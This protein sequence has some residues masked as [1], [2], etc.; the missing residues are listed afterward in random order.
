MNCYFYGMVTAIHETS[1]AL[2]ILP[3]LLTDLKVDIIL[4]I[5]Q[6]G[7]GAS[8][9]LTECMIAR[10]SIWLQIMHTFFLKG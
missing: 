1:F 7:D 9:R 5:S 4:L 6:L 3:L 2:N 8:K 10:S